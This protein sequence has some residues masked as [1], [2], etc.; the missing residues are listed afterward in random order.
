MT[1]VPSQALPDLDDIEDV[2]RVQGLG[3]GASE[4][5]G[6][7]C[8]WLAGGG[9]DS[10]RWLAQVLVDDAVPAPAAGGALDRL[11]E[12]SVAQMEDRGFGFDLL[13]PDSEA[14]L[15]ERS[16][17]LIDWCR[18]FLGGFGLASGQH[19]PLSEESREALEDLAKLA[20]ASPQDE[21]DDEDEDALI[22]IEE[23]VRVVALLLHGDCATGANHRRQL[24]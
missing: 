8:G 10:P 6:A 9:S 21:G 5:H 19:P 16:S 18:G 1:S 23:F 22:E 20:A 17:G 3:V 4:L 13:V 15:A 2:V 14:S 24:H 12:V 7:L 11:R